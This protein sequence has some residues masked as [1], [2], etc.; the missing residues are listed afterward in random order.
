MAFSPSRLGF[1]VWA[2][3]VAAAASGW[4]APAS[5]APA[6][7][8]YNEHIQPILAEYCF[9]CHGP[10]S[11]TRKAKLR[12]DRGEDA[13][14]QRDTHEPA[15]V[16]GKPDLSPLIERI[17][18][19]DDDERMPPPEAHKTLKPAE[20]A[21]LKR[22]IAEGATY[23]PHWAFVAPMRTASP[24]TR[25]ASLISTP[26]TVVPFVDPRSMSSS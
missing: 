11:G 14:A 9:H 24:P 4:A 16:P 2:G 7:L 22:W 10:D 17:L 3:S 8:S 23:E 21:L 25:Y 5:A 20:I 6:K 26:F 13:I 12:L 19:T 1:L 18:A 15:I